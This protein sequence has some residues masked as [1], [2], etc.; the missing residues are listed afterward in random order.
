M[1]LNAPLYLGVETPNTCLIWLVNTWQAA[2]V[3]NPLMRGSERYTVT[4]PS[5]VIPMTS[6][7]HMIQVYLFV[8]WFNVPVNNF[9]V[10]SGQSHRF[11]S[12]NQYSGELM[13]LAQGHNTVLLVQNEPMKSRFGVGCSTT[14]PPNIGLL[15]TKDTDYFFFP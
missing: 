1:S 3:V 15:N 13:C 10:M 12:F 7:K 6:C 14:L 8:L 5:R 2:P 4:K 11:L 9:S